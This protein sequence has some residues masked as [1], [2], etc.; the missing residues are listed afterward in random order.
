VHRR[1]VHSIPKPP[2]QIERLG[3]PPVK[4]H[5]ASKFE[6]ASCGRKNL[7]QGASPSQNLL[8]TLV[9]LLLNHKNQNR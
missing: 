7:L 9:S 6:F 5:S 1:G 8:D 2:A 3:V 4:I